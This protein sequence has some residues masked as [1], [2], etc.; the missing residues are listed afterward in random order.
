MQQ[1]VAA[2]EAGARMTHER[3]DSPLLWANYGLSALAVF[4]FDEAEKAY[5]RSASL[6]QPDFAGTAYNDIAVLFLQ[7]GRIAEA[8]DA[9]KRGQQHRAS[10]LPHLLQQDEASME[11]TKAMILL[12]A[13][14]TEEALRSAKSSYELPD[15]GGSKSDDDRILQLAATLG[16]AAAS[17]VRLEA[18]RESSARTGT[19]PYDGWLLARQIRKIADRDTLVSTLRPYL[20]GGPGTNNGVPS[21]LRV[22]I[23]RFFPPGVA[24][25]AVRQARAAEEH[26]QATGYLDAAEAE[27]QW[28][29]GDAAAALDLAEAALKQLP[30]EGEKLLRARVALVKALAAHELGDVHTALPMYE[31]AV[32][33]FPAAY[34][35]FQAA[36]P[37]DIQADER[38]ESLEV[39]RQLAR[40]PR[41]TR[42][43]QGFRLSVS[44]HDGVADFRLLRAD[45]SQ[46]LDE[47]IAMQ[48]DK[49]L[50][51][52]GVCAAFH[53]RL[54]SP[55]LDLLQ[56][57][58][59]SLDGSPFAAK[60]RETVDK[61]LDP[62]RPKV[63][64]D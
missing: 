22:S 16:Y 58:L 25:E 53:E 54:M 31:Q 17:Q 40:S 14:R 15:R 50:D 19:L 24:A 33:D 60:A 7:Q 21:W 44:V 46:V 43:E 51:T 63:Q 55:E 56:A 48:G 34:R 64:P 62:V 27:V 11:A 61:L 35:L 30:Q 4:R 42:D 28:L 52:A 32:R 57:D 6:G 59:G 18:L 26:P 45:S 20:A 36:L 29:S 10:R 8:V 37:V 47:T 38:A 9:Y 13:G 23:V 39:A 3:P 1:R 49:P 12:V 2:F 5:L 41:L